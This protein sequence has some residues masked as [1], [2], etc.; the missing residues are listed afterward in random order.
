MMSATFERPQ[1]FFLL[2]CATFRLHIRAQL[3]ERSRMVCGST[4]FKFPPDSGKL[5]DKFRFKP[6]P[7][8]PVNSSG[9][10]FYLLG[11]FFYYLII[12]FA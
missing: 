9:F 10:Y 7:N 2:S 3:V 11:F 12:K 4:R 1:L 6:V 8:T 5:S